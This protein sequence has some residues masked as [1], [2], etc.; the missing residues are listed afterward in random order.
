[1]NKTTAILFGMV[2]AVLIDGAPRAATAAPE[3]GYALA[4]ASLGP[5]NTD[6]FIAD[7]DGSNP[8]PLLAHAEHDYNASYSHD[9][10][11]IVFTS[12]RSGSA[13]IYR[14]HPDGSNLQRLTDDPAF[15]DQAA[16][17]PDG[18][19][20]AFVSTR[21]GQA[22]I[23]VQNLPNGTVRN[24]TQHPAGDFRPAWSPDGQWLAFS[25]DR[26]SENLRRD[27]V[28]VH[29]TEIYVVRS[30]GAELRRVTQIK[31][32]AG[33]PTWS[34]DG[35][36]LLFYRAALD[37]VSRIASARRLRGVTQIM[38]IDLATNALR[39][40]TAGEGEKWSPRSLAQDRVAYVSGGPG[41]GV[42]FTAGAAGAR[43]EFGSPSWT[44]DGHHMVFHRD[45]EQA[46]PPFR[47]QPSRDPQFRLVRTGIFPAYSPIAD[48][49]VSNDRTAAILHN[50]ILVMHANGSQRRTLFQD[51]TKGAL[52][53]AWS[54]R[55]DRV[56]FGLGR[57]FQTTL[58]PAAADIAVVNGDGAGL[59][60]LTDG[61]GNY[62]FPSWS[63]DGR[64]IVYRHSKAG[65]S[66]LTIVDAATGAATPMNTGADKEN[67]PS[68][69][70]VDDRI[71]FTS[72]RE[73]NYD[74]YT[75]RPDGT[76]LQRLTHS[77]GNEA[78]CTWSPDG[79]WIAFASA[80][81]G[82]KDEAALH[83][84]NPQPYGDIYV[85]RADGSD[86]RQLVDDQ[87]EDATPNWL[88]SGVL[89]KR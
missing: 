14:A 8:R 71:A 31:A 72:Y 82:F 56:A 77:P 37:D 66:G 12:L 67:F 23:W 15:D 59:K 16:L 48:R 22:E 20:L 19:S 30:D 81:Q 26:D 76:G 36:R 75:I 2:L 27:F 17:S 78:H 3:S 7:P 54:P 79:R 57:Y 87:F 29:S 21:S 52:A 70:P 50:V 44:T 83:P 49:L 47:E 86:V 42:E 5:L 85:M 39:E 18:K 51:P 24:V 65:K 35:K 13:D 33:S 4:Y 10:Q 6:I 61:A 53:P 9:G 80:Q 28:T 69:S 40:L 1:M 55:G 60:I 73:G 62:G 88:P 68:W 25:S 84:F 41:G 58:G 63:R 46:W 64:R 45:V 74:I 11:W 89:K 32:F 34:S 38:S 43:G